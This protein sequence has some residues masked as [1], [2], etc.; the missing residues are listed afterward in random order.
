MLAA[1]EI[2][3]KFWHTRIFPFITHWHKRKKFYIC[4]PLLNL[5]MQ[6]EWSMGRPTSFHLVELMDPGTKLTGI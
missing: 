6:P 5:H 1:I 2:C 3:E 4:E